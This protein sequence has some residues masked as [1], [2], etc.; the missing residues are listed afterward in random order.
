MVAAHHGHK[1]NLAGLRQR[2]PVSLK[3]STLADLMAVAS[4]LDLS[5]RAL[6]L[7]WRR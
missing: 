5:P 3:G 6:R 7:R 4:N 1:V 2:N